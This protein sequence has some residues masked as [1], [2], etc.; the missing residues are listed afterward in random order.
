MLNQFDIQVL[1]ELTNLD[2][3]KYGSKAVNFGNTF[4]TLGE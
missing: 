1:V 2:S 3:V 4:N